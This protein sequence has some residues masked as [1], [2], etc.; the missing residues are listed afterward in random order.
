[1]D[2]ASYCEDA[3][4][5]EGE[6]SEMIGRWKEQSTKKL[7]LGQILTFR[8]DKNPKHTATME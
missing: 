2:A 8:Q 6:P 3:L 1:M 7:L 4:S 5:N